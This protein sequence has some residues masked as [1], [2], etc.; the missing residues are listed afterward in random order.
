MQLSS[1][2]L[3]L[4][5]ALCAAGP[6]DA[7]WTADVRVDAY[8]D[9]W[10]TVVSPHAGGRAQATERL[11]VEARYNVDVVS[12]ATPVMEVDAISSATHFA[13]VRHQADISATGNLTPQWTLGGAYGASTEPDYLTHV[14]QIATTG[15]LLSRM[16]TL[17]LAY[18][19]SIE[20]LGSVHDDALSEP[21]HSH[22]VDL[23]WSHVLS[24]RATLTGLASVEVRSCAET[25]GCQASPYRF[26][27]V[28]GLKT[29]VPVR[30]RHPDLR[31]RGAVALQY[32]QFLG[33]GFALH[34]GYR[35]YADTW[36][37]D[38]HTGTLAV[39]WGGLAERLLLRLEGRATYQSKASFYEATYH[40]DAGVPEYRTAD[41]ELGE[42][43]SGGAVLQARWS[44]L[45]VG[46]FA[47]L[48]VN[49]RAGVTWYGYEDYPPLERLTGWIVGGG[50]HAEF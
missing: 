39:A 18:Q 15:E 45:S 9:G 38:G 40:G 49:A 3:L 36:A 19:A 41:K 6:A 50:V 37:V 27:G 1:R 26:V 17:S 8:G 31:V 48:G 13:E 7:Q 25:F 46:P 16:A 10:I 22:T 20:T 47:R 4:L 32:A 24:R 14:L 29:L 44:F 42:T 2:T 35:Y 34:A 21:A 33:R 43:W 11:V 28:R 5:G 23:S 12:G 30:E